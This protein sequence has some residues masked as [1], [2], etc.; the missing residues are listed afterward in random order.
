[1]AIRRFDQPI[2]PMTLGNGNRREA[3]RLSKN[4]AR[5][6]SGFKFA[7]FTGAARLL[8]LTSR[9]DIGHQ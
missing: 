7:P 6:G 5:R 3:F 1:M 4:E 9:D 8:L 2:E